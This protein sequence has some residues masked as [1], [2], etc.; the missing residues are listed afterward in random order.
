[1]KNQTK[2]VIAS[3]VVIALALTAVSGITYSWFSDSEKANI[4]VSTA[5]VDYKAEFK[6][7][8]TST[9]KNMELVSIKN[10]VYAISNLAA[11]ASGTIICNVTNNSTIATKYKIEVTPTS[12]GTGEN[13]FTIYDLVNVQINGEAL[14]GIGKS[15]NITKNPEKDGWSAEINAG[16]TVGDITITITT[17]ESYGGETPGEVVKYDPKT[18]VVNENGTETWNA[19][20]E[21]SGLTLEFKIIAVQSDYS[22]NTTTTP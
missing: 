3:I 1:M 17:P 9:P 11:N 14:T 13:S 10:G 18:G 16:G 21:R 22:T 6:T 4:T 8:E 5:V 2:A 15:V 19:Q 12:L 7:S 20:T